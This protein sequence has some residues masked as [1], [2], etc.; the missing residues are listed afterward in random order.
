[1]F[2]HFW[3]NLKWPVAPLCKLQG[4]W[5]LP[6]PWTLP[7]PDP[8]PEPDLAPWSAPVM[9]SSLWSRSARLPGPII[10]TVSFLPGAAVPNE[11]RSDSCAE[12]LNGC[13]WKS[14]KSDQSRAVRCGASGSRPASHWCVKWFT[15]ER[16]FDVSV[17]F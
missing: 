17:K 12:L 2:G 13:R 10:A 16:L 8:A 6:W 7:R 11:A 14:V 9:V 5:T 4:N 3:C 15:R 1:M